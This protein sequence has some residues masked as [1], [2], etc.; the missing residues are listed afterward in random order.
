MYVY[1]ELDYV[2]NSIIRNRHWEISETSLLMKALEYYSKKTQIKYEDIYI[3]DIGAN[4]GWYSIFFGKQGFKIISFE[5][6]QLNNYILRKNFCLHKEI[7]MTIINKGLY[8]EE[9]KCDLFNIEQ[10]KGNGLVICDHYNDSY[11][12]ID[13]MKNKTGEIILTKLSNYIPFLSQKNV[14]MIKIDI[15]GSEAR[16]I[17]GGIELITKYHI[18]FIFLEFTPSLL[19]LQGNDPKEFLQLFVDNGYKIS[20]Y[21]FFYDYVSV[22]DILKSKA[23][24]QNL[25]LVYS[26]IL[27]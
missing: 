11:R 20:L 13:L 16:A 4:I 27:E 10:N 18:P 2:S 21:N 14:A 22:E 5:P 9:R 25:Y 12:P 17:T 15:E 24:L 6:S 3:I 23:F 26:K 19:K 7:N 8:T 1:K